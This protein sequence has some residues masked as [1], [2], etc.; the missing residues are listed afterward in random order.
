[1][2]LYLFKLYPGTRFQSLLSYRKM[3]YGLIYVLSTSNVKWS[4]NWF[5]YLL[6]SVSDCLTEY[7]KVSVFS[8]VRATISRTPLLPRSL[9]LAPPLVTTDVCLQ[10]PSSL[11]SKE[12][13]YV[14]FF[15]INPLK[16][17]PS[18]YYLLVALQK[19]INLPPA[20]LTRIRT[21]NNDVK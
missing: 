9:S 15:L 20:I 18:S 14:S 13:A 21:S 6:K 2:K 8:W 1:M 12:N 7:R 3:M 17:A 16:Y 4:S 19:D 10:R 5:E 11:A